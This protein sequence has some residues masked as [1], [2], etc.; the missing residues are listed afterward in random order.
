MTTETEPQP[1]P[2]EEPLTYPNIFYNQRGNSIGSG[3]Y[4]G[5]PEALNRSPISTHPPEEQIELEKVQV[6]RRLAL[7]IQGISQSVDQLGRR[8]EDHQRLPNNLT[9]VAVKTPIGPFIWL[10]I[11][12][13]VITIAAVVAVVLHY[14]K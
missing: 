12:Q 8:V 10:A 2:P 9:T 6:L 3:F 1:T 5:M 11:A 7:G 13:S 14:A 4:P